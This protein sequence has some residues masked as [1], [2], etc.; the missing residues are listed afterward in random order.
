MKAKELKN[1]GNNKRLGIITIEG[2]EKD[3]KNKKIGKIKY[4]LQK[5]R[6]GKRR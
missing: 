5:K 1:N 6:E 4:K 2:K 3:R